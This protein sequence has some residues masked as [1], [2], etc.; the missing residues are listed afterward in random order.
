M[1]FWIRRSEA[2]SFSRVMS[3][4]KL[5]WAVIR[6]RSSFS[7]SKVTLSCLASLRLTWYNNFDPDK[8]VEVCNYMR[9]HAETGV[10]LDYD[11]NRVVTLGELTPE[12]WIG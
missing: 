6:M 7:S 4:Q 5:T 10:M 11:K 1:L 3:I 12:W 8:T 2:F 9:D